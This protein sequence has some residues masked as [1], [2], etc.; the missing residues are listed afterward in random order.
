[1][2]VVKINYVLLRTRMYLEGVLHYYFAEK[3]QEYCTC[4]VL[5]TAT[6]VEEVHVKAG[7]LLRRVTLSRCSGFFD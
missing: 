5:V 2:H 1:M 6:V 7:S 3:N 4:E